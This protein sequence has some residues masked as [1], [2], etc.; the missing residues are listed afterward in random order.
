MP[1]Q[2]LKPIMDPAGPS[3][4]SP[5]TMIAESHH[6]IVNDLALISSFVRLHAV[7]V[8]RRPNGM[9]RHEAGLLLEEIA[10]RIEAVAR[11]HRLLIDVP[12]GSTLDVAVYV[13]EVFDSMVASL[14]P[15]SRIVPS[16]ALEG[17]CHIA[18]RDAVAIGLIV[19]ELITNSIKYAHPANVKGR[20]HLACRRTADGTIVIEIEDDGVGL[21]EGFDPARDGHLG[22]RLLRSL[23][24]QLNARLHFEN[25]GLGLCAR[26]V[27]ASSEPD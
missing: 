24:Q 7:D 12:A 13:R 16:Y 15:M 23:I 5:E 9:S 14:A 25:C 27:I 20:M 6:R 10:A 11:L 8:A 21:P 19:G 17:H 2:I 26:I 18:S 1:E 22:F 3:P 4:S